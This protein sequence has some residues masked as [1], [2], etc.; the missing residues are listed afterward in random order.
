MQMRKLCASKVEWDY[1][2]KLTKTVDDENIRNYITNQIEWN[3][4][5][6]NQYKFCEYVLKFLNV[7]MPTVIVVMQQHLKSD[8][9]WL[10]MAVLGGATITAASST[11]LKFHDKRILYRKSAEQIKEETVL[12]ITHSGKYNGGERNERFVTEVDRIV[13]S[14][15]EQWGQIEVDKKQE[16]ETGKEVG[17]SQSDLIKNR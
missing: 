13:K 9:P 12:Y 6:A 14:A 15:N 11:F 17:R 10:Q 5:K 8:N 3:V 7:I 4:V 1:I 16:E 2:Y